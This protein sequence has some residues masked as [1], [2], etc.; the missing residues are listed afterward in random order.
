MLKPDIDR[1][2]KMAYLG[3]SFPAVGSCSVKRKLPDKGIYKE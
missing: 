1:L 2:P 3:L